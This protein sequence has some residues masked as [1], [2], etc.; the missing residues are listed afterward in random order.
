ML[1]RHRLIS[2]S[3]SFF[4]IGEKSDIASTHR[5]HSSPPPSS[6]LPTTVDSYT[7]LH[8]RRFLSSSLFSVKLGNQQPWPLRLR[9]PANAAI[10]F[11]RS[12]LSI[13][14]CMR[15]QRTHTLFMFLLS[16]RRSS[17]WDSPGFGKNGGI[18]GSGLSNR[19]LSVSSPSEVPYVA[20]DLGNR[21]MIRLGF[22]P[23][24]ATSDS[25]HGAK[26]S[27]PIYVQ[28]LPCIASKHEEA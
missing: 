16:F 14:P 4:S 13:A 20:K 27:S 9:P 21:V 22:A 8:H 6:L 7:S 3:S 17:K 10:S 25:S 2:S 1:K 5:L 28:P 26:E 11:S 15:N 19:R 18:A 12:N 23:C 24:S